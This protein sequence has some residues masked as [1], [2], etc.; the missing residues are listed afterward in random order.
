LIRGSDRNPVL[1]LFA[2]ADQADIR[3]LNLQ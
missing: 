1:V 3:R 2:M